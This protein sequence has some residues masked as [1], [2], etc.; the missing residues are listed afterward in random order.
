M[1]SSVNWRPTA[2]IQTLQKRAQINAQIREFFAQ[3]KVL[4]VETPA[5]AHASVTDINLHGFST[6]FNSP[7]KPEPD[8]LFLQ[9]SPE[10]AMKRLLCAGSGSI[11]Q[12]C[13]SFRNEEAGK[14]HNPE[15]TMLEWYRVGFNLSQL[16]DEVDELLQKILKT[17]PLERLSYQQAFLTYCDIDPL[18]CTLEELKR[19]ASDLGFANIA[20]NESV[21]DVL[22]QLLCSQVVEPEIGR[23]RPVALIDFPASQAALA[24]IKQQD[25]RV[26][27]RFEIYYKGLELANGYYELRDVNEQLSRFEKDRQVRQQNGLSNI[28]LDK[29]FMAAMENG[30]PDCS[31]VALG[32]DRLVMLACGVQNIEKVMS[33]SIDNA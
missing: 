24:R 4:E 21:K 5:L 6:Q 23:T 12:L 1:N 2:T 29:Y 10:F 33:F 28:A 31:G 16:I 7:L 26:A 13:K 15:F 25:P 27:E 9:T 14:Q 22:L 30:L 3:R 8:N 20:D 11:F 32:V 19:K 18:A 17:E